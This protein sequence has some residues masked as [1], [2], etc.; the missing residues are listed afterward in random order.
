MSKATIYEVMAAIKAERDFQDEKHG[1]DSHPIGSWLLILES[2]LAEAKEAAIKPASGRD[3]VI[4]EI[5]QIAAVCFAC[6][7]EHGI[8]PI[9]GR[10]V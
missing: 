3:N 9:E 10:T 6:L 8:E 2:E 4:A 1:T 5:I 7:E